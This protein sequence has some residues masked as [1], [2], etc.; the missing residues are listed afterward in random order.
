M[1]AKKKD[2]SVFDGPVKP[3][4]SATAWRHGAGE[5]AEIIEVCQTGCFV[6]SHRENENYPIFG[7]TWNEI[8]VRGSELKFP[9]RASTI[10]DESPAAALSKPIGFVGRLKD[11]TFITAQWA[12]GDSDNDVMVPV[13]A[14]SETELCAL[15]YSD[16]LGD[17]DYS[18]VPVFTQLNPVDR[19][20]LKLEMEIRKTTAAAK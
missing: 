13:M 2:P 7:A 12:M 8:Q 18:V 6:Q 15:A 16:K 11:G 14:Q 9:M 17:G 4:M 1:S 10:E 5:E 3:G 20:L 19:E